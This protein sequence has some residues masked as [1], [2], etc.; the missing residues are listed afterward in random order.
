[1]FHNRDISELSFFSGNIC[2]FSLGFLVLVP[3]PANL[4]VLTV[5]VRAHLLNFCWSRI[6]ALNTMHWE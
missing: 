3:I 4:V 2:Y 1:M 5:R 6:C